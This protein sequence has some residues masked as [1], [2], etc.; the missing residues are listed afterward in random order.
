MI[1]K[2]PYPDVVIPDESVTEYVLNRAAHLMDKV[3]IIDGT[4]GATISFRQL[5]QGIKSVASGLVSRGFAK[6]DVLAIYSPNT[7]TYPIAFHGVAHA[8]GVVTTVN[9][10]YLVSDLAG[11]LRDSGARFIITAGPF[12]DNACKAA[13]EVG[14][15]DEIFS[16]DGSSGTT[17]FSEL[18]ETGE[19]YSGASIN[20]NQDL[21][22]LPYSSGTTGISK[23]V[24]L[25]HQNLVANMAQLDGCEELCRPLTERDTLIAVLPFFHIYGLTVIMNYALSKGASI[26]VLPRFD[27]E[28][29]LA[30]VQEYGVTF[31][32]LV[33]PILVA[34]AKHP[35]VDAYDLTSL[36]GITS[37]A[38]PLGRELAEAVEGRLGCVV[39]QGYGLTETSPVTHMAPNREKGQTPHASVG[40]VLP[41][42]EVAIV[43]I[44]TGQRLGPGES[45]E[46]WIRGPQVM[47][48]YLGQP[49]A[50]G[51]TIDEEGWLHTGDIAYI[52]DRDDCYIVDR[53]KELIK[54]KGFQVAP[55]ELEALLLSNPHITDA[56]VVRSP[57]HEAGEIPKAFVVSD[58]SLSEEDVMSFVN[59]RVSPHKKIRRVEFIDQ[60]PKSPAG[61]ILRRILIDREAQG[62]E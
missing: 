19:P 53:V 5:A 3:A 8:G 60:I 22:T 4:N 56:A 35:I 57:D 61:K 43:D 7:P 41:N 32:H 46:L 47:Q 21:L 31:A 59:E 36:E 34:L 17:A 13:E 14:G 11:Q 20:L 16:F 55:A 37:G 38:A 10:T 58:G 29:F 6:G 42:T 40:P 1:F 28:Q 26:V 25:S 30:A 24:M 15:I 54:F 2:S 49:E 48:G 51:A 62:T 50:T 33:P 52:D 12:T 18:M 39:S 23:G 44:S 27:L 45:G 9:P